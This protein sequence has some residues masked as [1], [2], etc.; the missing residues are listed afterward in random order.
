[1]SQTNGAIKD[2]LEA[3]YTGGAY[4]VEQ[5]FQLHDTDLEDFTKFPL[6]SIED[7]PQEDEP[8]ANKVVERSYHPQLILY[9]ESASATL[10]S[11]MDAHRE[12]IENA[13]YGSLS[14]N[15]ATYYRSIDLITPSE[16]EDRKLQILTFDLTL[17]YDIHY[18]LT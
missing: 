5:D 8:Q 13:F 1:M 9:V 10:S 17:N 18:T 6:L 3:I 12:S 2:I 14:L 7:G 4:T 11:D 15:Q 16:E